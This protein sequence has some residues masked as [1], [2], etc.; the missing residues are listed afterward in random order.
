MLN[1]GQVHSLYVAPVYP[2]VGI[3]SW[4]YVVVDI[5]V[6]SCFCM[7]TAMWLNACRRSRDRLECL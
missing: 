1:L 7:L 6:Q 4:L 2:D 3:H 5:Y